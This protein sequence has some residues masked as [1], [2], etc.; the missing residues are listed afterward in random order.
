MAPTSSFVNAIVFRGNGIASNDNPAGFMVQRIVFD[1]GTGSNQVVAGNSLEINGYWRSE[2]EQRNVGAGTINNDLV[3]S[4]TFAMLGDGSGAI[5]ING[6]ISGNNGF[7]KTGDWMLILNG[8]NSFVGAVTFSGG[9]LQIN[10]GTALGALAN[11]STLNAATL[12][13]TNTFSDAHNYMLQNAVAVAVAS[14]NTFTINGNVGGS[15]SLRKLSGGVL[16][17]NGDNTYTGATI[18]DDGVL[19]IN[20]TRLVSGSVSNSGVLVFNNSGAFSYN[21]KISGSG[22]L[23]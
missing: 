5:T 18:I 12:L 9:T 17:L 7:T 3:L 23:V 19:Q 16:A 20:G 8:S 2:L 11:V 14:N 15:G 22:N 10:S 4:N 1:V 21:G 6:Q 13:V